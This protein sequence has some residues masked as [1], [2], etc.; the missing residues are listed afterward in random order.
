MYKRQRQFC[1]RFKNATG[2][3]PGSY[4]QRLRLEFVKHSLEHSQKQPSAIIW[5]T[6]YEDVSSFRRLFK[7]ETGL[8]MN[9]Y[10]K[11][12]GT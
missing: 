1:R 8:T 12:F 5:D 6:G 3:S 10:R 4:I 9:E 7:R 2:D 11:R